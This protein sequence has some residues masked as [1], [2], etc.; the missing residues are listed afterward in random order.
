MAPRRGVYAMPSARL[1]GALPAAAET[2]D[3]LGVEPHGKARG[4]VFGGRWP[5]RGGKGPK[6]GLAGRYSVLVGCLRP[7][8][9]GQLLSTRGVWGWPQ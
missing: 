3:G 7:M 6:N 8:Q 5:H 4:A 2:L 9:P 1:S